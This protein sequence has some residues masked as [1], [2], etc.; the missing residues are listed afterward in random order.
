MLQSYC[1][2]T[3]NKSYII[4]NIGLITEFYSIGN[5][6]TWLGVSKTTI[7][8]YINTISSLESPLLDLDVFIIDPNRPLTNKT[9]IFFFDTN[10]FSQIKDFDLYSLRPHPGAR[11]GPGAI[12]KLIAL[13]SNKDP[14]NYFGVFTNAAEAALKLDNKTEYKYISRYINLERTVEVTSNKVKVY[15]VMNPRKI[16]PYVE[17]LNHLETLKQ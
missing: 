14:V 12:G 17:D 6:A 13:N 3:I 7:S 1:N 4:Q 10:L 8:R 5:A 2:S 15:F 9:V 11:L 16:S